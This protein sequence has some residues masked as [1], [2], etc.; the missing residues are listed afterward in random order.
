VN[1][2]R[3]DGLVAF[4]HDAQRLGFLGPGDVARQIRH[5]EGFATVV[6]D[7]RGGERPRSLVDLGSG[8]GLPG[9]VLASCWPESTVV[10]VD[11]SR[12]RCAHLRSARDRLGLDRLEVLEGRAEELA[13]DPRWR[14]AFDVATARGFD[15]PPRTAE[16]A[17]GFVRVGGVAVVSE[18]PGLRPDRWPA[19]PLAGL[20]WSA[21]TTVRVSD[22]NF[23]VLRKERPAAAAHPRATRQLVKRPAW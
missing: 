11:A 22:A 13:H 3:D 1:R 8:G 7:A 6:L 23:A 16:V 19:A 15:V 5:A 18:P 21:A 2:E 20:G 12:R 4:F 14:E 10:L 17:A 9:V